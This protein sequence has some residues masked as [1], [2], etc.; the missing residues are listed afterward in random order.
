MLDVFLAEER[1][2]F[3][4]FNNYSAPRERFGGVPRGIFGELSSGDGCGGSGVTTMGGRFIVL[5]GLFDFSKCLPG[6]EFVERSLITTLNVRLPS[7]NLKGAS[8]SSGEFVVSPCISL[9]CFPRSY[10][11]CR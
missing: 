11:C 1:V 4:L 6:N 9:F 10:D 3:R 7:G 2:Y 5:G 8:E